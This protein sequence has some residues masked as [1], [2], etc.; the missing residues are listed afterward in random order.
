MGDR[1]VALAP[2]AG[3][4]VVTSETGTVV[5]LGAEEGS[6]SVRMDDGD[7][8]RVLQGQEI[9][10]ERLAHGY[11]VTVH[12]SQ[13]ATVERAHALE[14]G[15]GRELAYVKMS[16]STD[17]STVYVVADSVEQAAEDLC[18]EWKVERRLTWVIDRSAATERRAAGRPRDVDAALRRGELVAE[19]HAILA[20][21]PADPTAAIRAAERDLDRLRRRR[22]DLQTGRGSYANHPLNRAVIVHEQAEANV[23]RLQGNL[24]RR[25]L[26][27]GEW[28]KRETELVQWRV[29][30]PGAARTVDDIRTPERKQIDRDEATVASMLA[31]LH[32]QRERRSDW[33]ASH[34]EAAR[35]LDRI[36]GEVQALDIVVEGLAR[37]T[38]DGAR[39]NAQPTVGA[40]CRGP[41]ALP[42]HRPRAVAQ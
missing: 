24:D 10:A 11:A 8:E 7:A 35:R 17:R 31:D 14:D 42:R 21:V 9:G 12:R 15:G 16:R 30:L 41:R 22:A 36:D 6:L 27:R 1:V 40:G 25:R 19:R 3:G 28:R 18:R 5:A 38:L 4:K 26:P 39:R 34:P 13:G 23:T 20:A 32:D 29:Q 37:G 33:F 2:A